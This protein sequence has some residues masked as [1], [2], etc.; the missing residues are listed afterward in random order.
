M[1]RKYRKQVLSGD[2]KKMGQKFE[3]ETC[4]WKG[5]VVV[6]GTEGPG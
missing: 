6:L 1:V 4:S 3:S 5:L 2:R